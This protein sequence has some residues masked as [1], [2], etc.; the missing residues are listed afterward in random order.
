MVAHV[1]NAEGKVLARWPHAPDLVGR[2]LRRV[3]AAKLA[4][5]GDEGL[6]DLVGLDG[7]TRVSAFA[8]LRDIPGR[9]LYVVA[10]I[11]RGELERAPRVMLQND[12]LTLGAALAI[13]LVLG[14]L[15]AHMLFVKP[16]RK[17]T[18]AADRYGQGDL[19]ARSGLAHGKDEIGKLARLPFQFSS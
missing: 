9:P 18:A 8:K 17:L 5:K 16:V 4:L 14:F 2:E 12:L 7:V 3:G 19:T 10:G 15:G 6:A 1:V 13:A 11:P